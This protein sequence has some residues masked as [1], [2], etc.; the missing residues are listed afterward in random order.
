MKKRIF[1]A[2]KFSEEFKKQIAD[3]IDKL[4]TI[5]PDV[6][7]VDPRNAHITLVFLG[8]CTEAE[9]AKIAAVAKLATKNQNR[10]NLK[11]SGI[12]FFPSFN[13]P[14]IIWVSGEE[15]IN[16]ISLQKNLKKQLKISGFVIEERAFIPHVTIGRVKRSSKDL[17]KIL[18]LTEDIELSDIKVSS[19]DIME[20]FLKNESAEHK[21]IFKINFKK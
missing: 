16:L 1:L 7:Y 17:K 19:I 4:R 14:K 18:A 12:G 10:F 9:I 6:K 13:L 11:F 5:T 15:S 20:S 21:T 3:L 2:I 8:S